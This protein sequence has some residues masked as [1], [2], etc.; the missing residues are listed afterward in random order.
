MSHGDC[1]RKRWSEWS[2]KARVG[3]VAA[4][5]VFVPT[6]LVLFAAL[7]TGVNSERWKEQAS[8]AN[9][10]RSAPSALDSIAR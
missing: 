7:V 9:G 1:H 4:A 6:L 5:L 3:L 8:A 2:L 10:D